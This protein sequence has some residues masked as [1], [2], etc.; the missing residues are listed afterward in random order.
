MQAKGPD[1]MKMA[2]LLCMLD[3]ASNDPN[4]NCFTRTRIWSIVSAIET[5]KNKR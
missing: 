5:S 3:E 2:T 4:V 1:E